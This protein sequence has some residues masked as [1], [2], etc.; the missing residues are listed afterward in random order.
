M[1]KP[2]V[3][4]ISFLMVRTLMVAQPLIPL[5]SHLPQGHPRLLATDAYKPVLE[6]QI[7]EEAWAR[8][9][10]DGILSRIDPYVAKTQT[11]PDWLL[12]RLMMYWTSKA[13]NV[14]IKGGVYSHAD[15]EA[16]VP[17]VRFG[18]TRGVASVYK[19]PRLEDIIPYMDDTK[20]VYFHNSG[21]EG[22]PLEWTEQA[23]VSG[24]NIESVN[25]EIIKLAKDAS[26]VYW[27]T[28]DEKY[29]RFAF[30]LFDTYMMGMYYRHE[31]IDLG[32]G[33]A[34]TLV[35]LSTFEVIQERI[36][37]ELAYL[38]DFLHGYVRRDHPEKMETYA[39][40]LKKWVDI[41]I[42]NGVPQNNWNLHQAK[43]ILKVAMV[44][45]DNH[46]YPDG[47]GREYYID[48]ILNKTSPRQWPLPEFMQ[49]GY[50]P[51]TGVWAECPGYAL[52]VTKDLTNFIRDYG[53]TFGQNLLPYFPVM[54]KAVAVL[55]QYLFP[56]NA[57]T[58]WGDTY[59]SGLSTEA[60]S[61]M[62][63]MA[64][65]YGNREDEEYF[66]RLYRLLD[67]DI[68]AENGKNQRLAPQISSFFT[69]KPLV[70]DTAIPKGQPA[71]YLTPTFYAPNVS[72]FVQRNGFGSREHGLM[73]S[74][75]ASYGN[76]AHSNGISMELYG[77]GFVLGPE[78]GIGSSYF[79][80]PYLEYYSQFPAH[81]TVMVDG[82]S[83]YPEMLSNHP[84][85]LVACYPRPGQESGYYP[86]ITFSDVAFVEPESRSDQT[87]LLG[88][89]RTGP[90]SGY[91]ID[92]FRSRRQRKGDK[93][94]DYFYHNLGQELVVAD[95]GNQPLDLKPSDEMA[96]AGGHLFA[97]DYMWDKKSVPVDRDY[98]A[99]WK[100]A[101]PDGNH[102][103]MNLWMKGYP[104]REVFSIKAPPCKAFRNN[105]DFPY[106]V[107]KE[108]FLTIAARQHGEAWD[109]PFVSVFEPATEKEPSSVTSIRSF[110]A[111]GASASF[112]GLRIESENG[113]TDHVFSSDD[114]RAVRYGNMAFAGTYAVVSETGHETTLFLGHGQQLSARGISVQHVQPN[115]NAVVKVSGHTLGLTANG[116]FT[117]TIPDDL[118]GGTVQLRTG[119][120]QWT[121][122]RIRSKN[123]KI[124]E[125]ELPAMDWTQAEVVVR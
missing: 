104:D 12:S 95:A 83:K 97:L 88:I 56:N 43:I 85:D 109:R 41:T 60:V 23:N 69:D 87:R 71:D 107:N 58:A 24:S 125:F 16:P 57:V 8:E 46:T 65:K 81:N 11:Q 5:P 94:H 79:E 1:R 37:A 121:G 75:V 59:Y 105:N 99:R 10:L 89:V 73:V 49:Y 26:F 50:D 14:Y 64:Q 45:E 3:V 32:N 90:T 21:K 30:N 13:A 91:Y 111:Q 22:N 76:H 19:R 110:D 80:K 33:H 103:Y 63:R 15:G 42:K 17:T 77:K 31:P 35:G 25:E 106:E 39:A 122:K 61:D 114:A 108:P 4:V 47:K 74:Q 92:I 54:H 28:G 119:Q 116:S 86:G 40:I 27:L 18:S 84:F 36:L 101:M 6:K 112:V 70:L 118:A 34:Q 66:T 123:G 67:P 29:A 2:L 82:I 38:Y 7:A 20:G 98:K 115:G 48:C 100:M 9:V 124:V 51:Q 117:L 53:N 78:S 102:V 55:P 44:L 68:Q 93:F 113:R 52:G 62:V 120:G 96:F 72:W